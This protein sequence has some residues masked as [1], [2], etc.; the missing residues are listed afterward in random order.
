[1]AVH[2]TPQ[3]LAAKAVIVSAPRPNRG[4]RTFDLHP[5][6]HLIVAGAWLAFVAI[7]CAAFWASDLAVP[8]AIFVIGVIAL[9]ATPAMWARV[10]PQDG[11][12]KPSWAEFRRE[13]VDCHT[14]H[15]TSGEALA[16]ILILPAMLLGLAA[17]MA[18]IKLTL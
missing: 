18:A 1:M 13:G 14:G 15:L 2:Q 11:L 10:Q 16:Q 4:V 7:L 9:F 5:A 3:Q 6:V 12:R 8:A 17:V